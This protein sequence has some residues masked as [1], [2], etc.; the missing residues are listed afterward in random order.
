M[1]AMK[2]RQADAI[3]GV[4]PSMTSSNVSPLSVSRALAGEGLEAA[5]DNIAIKRIELDDMRRRC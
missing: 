2:T 1:R 4:R 5:D 3:A